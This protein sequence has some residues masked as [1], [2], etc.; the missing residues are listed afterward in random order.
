MTKEEV[1]AAFRVKP[2]LLSVGN[3]LHVKALTVSDFN[4]IEAEHQEGESPV[5]QMCRT[6]SYMLCD[7]DGNRLFDSYTELL[8]MPM[9]VLSGIAEEAMEFNG[10]GNGAATEKN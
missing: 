2:E 1:I 8:D 6:L 5:T 10:L 4:A 9:A 7:A 3:G